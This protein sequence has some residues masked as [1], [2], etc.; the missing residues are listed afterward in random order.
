MNPKIH[1]N[2]LQALMI[3]WILGM[4]LVGFK[5]CSVGFEASQAF[6]YFC[7]SFIFIIIF[8]GLVIYLLPAKCT[9]SGC[10]GIMYAGWDDDGEIPFQWRL[11]F[12]CNTCEDVFITN[13]TIGLGDGY[14]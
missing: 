13:F 4:F 7:G 11:V 10:G 12:R 14:Y 5:S 6:S 3:I 8:G 2:I 9:R 1:E